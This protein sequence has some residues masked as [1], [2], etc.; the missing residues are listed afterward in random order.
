VA[1]YALEIGVAVNLDAISR[2][3]LEYAA[4]LHDLG[5]L[6]VPGEVLTKPGKLSDAEMQVIRQHPER[7]AGMVSR[8]PPLR[9]LA[10]YV[11]KH[12][13]WF[14]GGG[15]PSASSGADIPEL[16]L[17]LS[18][19]DCFDAM[20][21]TRAYRPAM[22]RDEAVA[23]L[24]KFAGTQ[25]DPAVVRAFIEA[26]VGVE[27]PVSAGHELDGQPSRASVAGESG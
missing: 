16:A 20:T 25:F 9:D 8:I 26:R 5:K 17:I 1:A 10:E 7:G 23:E 27:P 18:V 4:L 22:S 15:Y 11:S 13:E 6:A 3:R 24:I 2:E 14:N 21:T 19:A 12:H